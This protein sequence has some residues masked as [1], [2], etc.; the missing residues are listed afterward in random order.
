VAFAGEYLDD[1]LD[2]V[3][4]SDPP[5]LLFFPSVWPETF[6]YTLDAALR[7]GLHPACFDVGAPARRLRALGLG[8]VL[9]LELALHPRRLNDR[10]L[11]LECGRHPPGPD[12]PGRSWEGA[13]AYYAPLPRASE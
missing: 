11:S 5:H 4:A 7:T 6:S 3:L 8:T 13:E 9:P 12:E 2:R 1:E 10:L